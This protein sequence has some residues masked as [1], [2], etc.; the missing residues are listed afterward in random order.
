MLRLDIRFIY[1]I[2]VEGT[3]LSVAENAYIASDA[4]D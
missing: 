4:S 2:V 1:L 3:T